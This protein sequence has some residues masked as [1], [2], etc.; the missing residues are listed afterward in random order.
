ME[1]MPEIYAVMS[2]AVLCSKNEGFP[3]VLMEAM[4]AGVPIVA[5]QVG[6]IP[7]LVQHDETGILVSTRAP[8]DYAAAIAD[9]Q[10]TAAALGSFL[11]GG[12]DVAA[13]AGAVTPSLYRQRRAEAVEQGLAIVVQGTGG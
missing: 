1:E 8:A 4:A 10:S 11:G 13:M 7:E 2:V 6:G 3:N 5:S 12:L 9:T